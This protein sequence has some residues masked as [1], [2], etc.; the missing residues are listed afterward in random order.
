MNMQQAT[1]GS[2]L[3]T[4]LGN[5]VTAYNVEKVLSENSVIPSHESLMQ[6]GGV[7]SST[8][9][10]IL[11]LCELSARYMVGTKAVTIAECN[12]VAR[13]MSYLKFESKEHFCVMTLDSSNHVINVHEVSIGIVNSVQCHPRE[14]FKKAI[15]DDAV[16]VIFIHNHHSGNSEASSDDLAIT[17]VL[18]AAGRI[19][20]IPV[21]D[22]VII[23]KG[24]HTSICKMTPETFESTFYKA[25]ELEV[26]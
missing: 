14:A 17:K 15:L 13:R 18:C 10:K 25:N 21:L 2:L 20:K 24:G 16:S 3:T 1:I 6:I 9:D 4:I 8:A 19:L 5:S 11:A 22:H 26:Q 7:G 23:A 12:D